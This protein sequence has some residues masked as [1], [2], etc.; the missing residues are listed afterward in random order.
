MHGYLYAK[1]EEIS[2]TKELEDINRI[3]KAMLGEGNSWEKIPNHAS[4]LTV[5]G[6]DF[7]CHCGCNVFGKYTNGIYECNAC[8]EKYEAE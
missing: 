8:K 6:E 5:A 3:I 4:M 1:A 7:R 2:K